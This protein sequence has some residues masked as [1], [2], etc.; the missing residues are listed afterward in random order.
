MLAEPLLVVARVAAALEEAGVL[1]LVGGSLASSTYGI[2]R[3]T[4]DVDL[5]A[6]LRQEHVAPLVRA[7]EAEF[8][9][10][11]GMVRDAIRRRASFNVI[12]LATAYKADIFILH[13]SPWAR[14]EMG[15]RR[16]E[17]LDSEDG[18]LHLYLS[19]PEDTILH[20]LEWYR[21]G[22]GACPTASRAMSWAC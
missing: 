13:A 6:G 22:G 7:L 12:H 11:A 10:D 18:A 21:Q 15:R 3:A 17:T 19:S 5:V 1:Y 14:E 16:L 8:Y 2:P 20:K 4:Q 9:I